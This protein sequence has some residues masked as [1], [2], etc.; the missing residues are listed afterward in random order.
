MTPESDPYKVTTPFGPLYLAVMPATMDTFW[1]NNTRVTALRPRIRVASDPA[2]EADPAHPDHFTIRGRVYGVHRSFRFWPGHISG[3]HWHKEDPPHGGGYRNDKRKL[4]EF[5]T[6]TYN[7]IDAAVIAALDAFATDNP[8]WPHFSEYL[9]WDGKEN[10]AR[11]EARDLERQAREQLV[12]AAEYLAKAEAAQAA[13]DLDAYR[14]HAS[15][16]REI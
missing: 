14:R 12:K 5:Q 11:A 13:I 2:F 7:N 9:Y 6:P 1:D 15:A 10:A 3:D 16:S 8:E 4:V